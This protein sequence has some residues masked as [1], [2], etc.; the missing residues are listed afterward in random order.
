MLGKAPKLADLVAALKELFK[1][2]DEHGNRPSQKVSALW[3][4][5]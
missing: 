3:E 4:V 2:N 1:K 5:S